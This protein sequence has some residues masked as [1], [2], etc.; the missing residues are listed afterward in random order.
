MGFPKGVGWGCALLTVGVLLAGGGATAKVSGPCVNCHTMHNSQGGAP[1]A[2]V[3]Q[4]GSKVY[5]SAP[6]AGLLNTDCIGC[7]QG[8]NT[9]SS[10]PYVFSVSEPIY[11]TTGTEAGTNT[12]AGGNFYWVGIN[13]RAGH[14]VSGVSNVDATL[15]TTPPGGTSLGS[16][17]GCAG[18]YGC[19]GVSSEANGVKAI[20]GAH[21]GAGVA[22]WQDG[23]SVDRSYRAIGG[24]QGL[25]DSDYEFQPTSNAHNK[26]YG[27][28][29]SGET[30]IPAGTI[31]SHC[32]RC[33]GNFHNG[34]GKIASGTFGSG[35]WLR[36]PVDFDM[37]R[38][39]SSTEYVSYN[40]AGNPYSVIAPVATADTTTTLNT[41]VFKQS[42]DAIVMCLS[43]H[44]A[45]GTPYNSILRWNYKA[46]P[47][48]GY[49]GCAVCHTTK[50]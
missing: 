5:T 33:H 44:R 47:A 42:N 25:E 17:L 4:G 48:G 13:D 30:Q 36:H 22:G 40:G 3:M 39:V 7:H 45:H 1:V 28:N 8:T 41:G 23:T 38:A 6:N 27:V 19:H 21:H 31:S 35:V 16:Q 14:N 15:S 20:A 9:G 32:A 26:Y 12:L 46:W 34:S 29:R 43:C 37:S 24:L 18:T 11:S 50:D 10:T 2:Y 49:N